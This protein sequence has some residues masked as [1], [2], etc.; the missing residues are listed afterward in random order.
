[1]HKKSTRLLPPE[2]KSIQL[3]SPLHH[4]Q[5]SAFKDLFTCFINYMIYVDPFLLIELVK[6]Y[7]REKFNSSLSAIQHLLIM[8]ERF[9]FTFPHSSV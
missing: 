5:F 3:C 6:V 1:M 4:L 9:A 8:H 2:T 7:L